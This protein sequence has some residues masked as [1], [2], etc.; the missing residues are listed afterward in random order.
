MICV[1]DQT[2]YEYYNEEGYSGRGRGRNNP[3]MQGVPNEGPIPRGKWRWG[4]RYNSPNTGRNTIELI[5]LDNNECQETERAC[6]TFRAHG[7]NARSDASQGCLVLPQNRI[8]IP[9]GEILEV[10][11]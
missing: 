8:Q 5:P 1:D 11:R 3:D 6:D 2:G 4:R 10:I 7:N 9:E